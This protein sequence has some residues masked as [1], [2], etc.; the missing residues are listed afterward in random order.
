MILINVH[1]FFRSPLFIVDLTN[2]RVHQHKPELRQ[3]TYL[4]HSDSP[5][6][7]P[8]RTCP[9]WTEKGAGPQSGTCCERMRCSSYTGADPCPGTLHGAMG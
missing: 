4:P 8:E 1:T 9:P 7:A 6:V 3:R 5:L 2:Q